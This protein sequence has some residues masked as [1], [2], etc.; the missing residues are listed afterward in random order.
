MQAPRTFVP[1][2]PSGLGQP[3]FPPGFSGHP[4]SRPPV[5]GFEPR[6]ETSR[7]KSSSTI[8]TTTTTHEFGGPIPM[9]MAMSNPNSRSYNSMPVGRNSMPVPTPYQNGRMN[10][11]PS[12]GS[13][14]DRP[15]S[16]RLESPSAQSGPQFQAVDAGDGKNKRFSTM[17]TGTFGMRDRD[18]LESLAEQEYASLTRF[19][20]HYQLIYSRTPPSHHLMVIEH[21]PK[22]WVQVTPVALHPP[23]FPPKQRNSACITKQELEQQTLNRRRAHL[24]R[25]LGWTLRQVTIPL[26]NILRSPLDLL[27][28][29]Y[30]PLH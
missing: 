3:D 18:Q 2:N 16:P 4:L 13:S 19:L 23:G 15:L 7:R 10:R 11:T 12:Y 25:I 5:Q 29:S 24:C 14:V 1:N 21:R 20:P 9:S 26:L 6:P 28:P 27:L 17:T 22:H 8:T 30:L